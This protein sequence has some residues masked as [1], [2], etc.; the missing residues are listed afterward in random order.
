MHELDL[1]EYIKGSYLAASQINENVNS[2]VAFYYLLGR[3]EF[4]VYAD[5]KE[6]VEN[7]N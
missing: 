3:L 2:T 5:G 7:E 6:I 1:A 4:V